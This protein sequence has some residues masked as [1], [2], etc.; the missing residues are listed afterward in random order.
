MTL[1]FKNSHGEMRVVAEFDSGMTDKEYLEA[2]EKEIKKFCD[3]RN[4]KIYYTRIWHT[5]CKGQQMTKFDVGSHTE[6]FYL[7]QV[8]NLKGCVV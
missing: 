2:A 4:F 7:D 5:E 6:F 1:Y 3:A 8:V